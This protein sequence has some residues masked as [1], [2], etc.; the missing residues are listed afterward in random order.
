MTNFLSTILAVAIADF[1]ERSRR[2][3][4]WIFLIVIAYA[5]Y[6]FIPDAGAPYTTVRLGAYRGLYNSAWIGSQVTLMSIVLVSLVGFY[7]IKGSVLREIR[8][9]TQELVASS[10][11]SGFSYLAGK[12]LSNCLVLFSMVAVLAITSGILQIARGEDRSINL[13]VLLAPYCFVMVP[14]MVA[15]ATLAVFFDSI[16]LLRGG[17]GNVAFFILWVVIASTIAINQ[18]VHITTDLTP[19]FDLFGM[20][21]LWGEMMKA[22]A[23]AVSDY[24][25][26]QGP[27]SLGFHFMADGSAPNLKTFVFNGVHWSAAFL[28]G[29]LLLLGAAGAILAVA[30]YSFK[31]FD[32][33]RTSVKQHLF[34]KHPS[35][36]ASVTPDEATSGSLEAPRIALLTPIT[37]HSSHLGLTSLLI[38]ELRIALNRISRWWYI[39]AAG[40][41]VAGM[42]TPFDISYKF[43]LAAAWFWP[44]LIWSALGCRDQLYDTRQMVQST[45]G[46]VWVQLSMQWLAG[47]IIAAGISSFIGIRAMISG[48]IGILAHWLIGAMFIPSLAMTCGLMTS[49][50]K[51]FEVLYTILFYIGPLNKVPLCDFTGSV[52]YGSIQSSLS[53]WGVITGSLL[54]VTIL[55]RRWQLARN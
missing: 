2:Y 4:F 17:M 51:L 33:E 54:L 5:T 53:L 39:V 46:G 22:C 31:R 30:S 6:L 40:I 7:F 23:A 44:M 9:K 42:L 37:T 55:L 10:P 13:I 8:L 48:D 19:M 41:I 50:R 47:F 38:A 20:N 24:Q 15:L 3:S 35:P 27:H 49:G 29:R 16:R 45:P 52:V 25:P 21:Y 11:I 12:A 26:W 14:L 43:L 28:T 34:K 1:R 18:N 32:E 36:T